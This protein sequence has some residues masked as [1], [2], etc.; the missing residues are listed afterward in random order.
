MIVLD[1]HAWVWLVIEPNRLGRA[2]K[3]EIERAER[4]IVSAMSCFEVARLVS[5]RRLWLDRSPGAWIAR[6]SVETNAKHE[7]V[8]S[9]IAVRAAELD[10]T[11]FPGDPG[12]R[13][14]YATAVQHRAKLITRDAAISRFDPER[15]VWD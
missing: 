7:P 4:I 8:S 2:A 1:T 11:N 5:R 10:Q 6:A 12:D 3:R 13:I 9:E 14:I 15:A